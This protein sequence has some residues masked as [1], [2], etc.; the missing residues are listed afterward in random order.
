[1]KNSDSQRPGFGQFAVFLAIVLCACALPA[2]QLSAADAPDPRLKGLS[3]N[4]GLRMGENMY[5]NGILPNGE[6]MQAIVKGDIPVAGNMFTCASC[7]LRSGFGT[8]EGRVRTAPIDGSRLYS[9]L[10]RFKGV[11]LKG[12]SNGLK[13]GNVYRPAYTDQTLAMVIQTGE[14]PAGRRITDVMPIYPLNDR[15]MGILVYYLKNLSTGPQPGVTDTSLRFATVVT[16]EVNKDDREAMLGPLRAFIDHWR[17]SRNMERMTRRDA[18]LQE[19]T[20]TGLRK[21]SLSV[22]ELKGPAETWRK[23]LEE[24]YRKDPVFGL[25]GGITTGEWAPIHRFCEDHKIPSVFPITDFPVISDTD[26]YTLYLSKGF[27]QEGE[28][29][30][31]YLHGRGDLPKDISVIQVFR[32]DRT[33]LV[34]SKAF[35]E[36]WQ[37]LGRTT[38]ENVILDGSERLTP[39]FWKK[40]FD[41]RPHSVLLLWLNAKDFPALDDLS[42]AQTRPDMVFASSGLLGQS[43]YSLPEKARSLIYITYPYSLPQDSQKYKSSIEESLSKNNVPITNR[44]IEYKMFSLFSTLTGPFSMMRSNIY[45]DSFLE[46]IESS[47][48]ISTI[49]ITY[50]RLSF[51]TGQRYASKGCYIVQLSEGPAPM[52]IKISEWVIY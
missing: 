24:Y 16:D 19:G 41:S 25:L 9:P 44:E 51:G 7:H 37:G 46:L 22:W 43:L 20:S 52:L 10:S 45:R 33:G 23:Q 21:L 5:L 39:V 40:L 13:N 50:P 18:Y 15:D 27:H 47:P 2:I 42:Q 12:Q 48:D 8:S 36:T 35:Q 6:P 3:S 38:P 11:P 34:L 4:D 17:I 32:N 30:A 31:K 49:P 29:A 28:T 1:M 26:W 14:D